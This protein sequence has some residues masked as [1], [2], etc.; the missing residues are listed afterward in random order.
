MNIHIFGEF[1]VNFEENLE[2][3][4]LEFNQTNAKRTR[5]TS[6]SVVIGINIDID[7]REKYRYFSHH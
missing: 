1:S 4:T 2:I 3:P 7:T 5:R 6:Y